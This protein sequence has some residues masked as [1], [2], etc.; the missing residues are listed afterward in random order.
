MLV[1]DFIIKQVYRDKYTAV[2]SFIKKIYLAL[3][4]RDEVCS[5]ETF[6]NV[7]LHQKK[8]LKKLN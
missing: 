1:E 7:D 8:H 2:F 3:D 5:G 6:N 4:L